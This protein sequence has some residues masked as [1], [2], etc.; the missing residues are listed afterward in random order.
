ME[1]P[2]GKY[3]MSTANIQITPTSYDT[4]PLLR[5]GFFYQRKEKACLQQGIRE[6]ISLMSVEGVDNMTKIS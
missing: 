4:F 1:R 2:E 6:F 3:K 5:E